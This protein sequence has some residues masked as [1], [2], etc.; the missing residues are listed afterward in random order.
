MVYFSDNGPNSFRLTG[1]M[2]GRKGSTDEGGLRSVCYI[3]WPAKIPAG[4]T[5]TQ[6]AG[7]IDLL[8]TITSLAGVKRVGDKPLDGR[9][10]KPL[11]M[12]HE[13]DWS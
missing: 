1:G 3:R 5:V 8:P 9:D 12:Q 10:L 2:K 7:A 4:H 6:I 11:L 13:A